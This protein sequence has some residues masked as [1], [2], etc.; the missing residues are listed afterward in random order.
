LFHDLFH[1]AFAAKPGGLIY[2]T[3]P[4]RT[5]PACLQA[6]RGAPPV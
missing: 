2:R 1:V 5:L 4:T 6:D 3:G